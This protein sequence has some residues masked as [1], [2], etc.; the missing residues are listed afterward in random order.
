MASIQ[1]A[2]KWMRIWKCVR[3]PRHVQK[4]YLQ[5]IA[6]EFVDEKGEPYPFDAEDLLAE[7]WEIYESN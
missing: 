7:D 1:Q 3:T 2:V 5:E 4:F 6:G